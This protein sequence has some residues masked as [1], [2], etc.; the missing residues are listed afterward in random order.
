[1]GLSV[2]YWLTLDRPVV[3]KK[4]IEINIFILL[5]NFNKLRFNF[6][7]NIQLR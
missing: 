6:N 1:M 3:P 2:R 4:G 7:L 5:V